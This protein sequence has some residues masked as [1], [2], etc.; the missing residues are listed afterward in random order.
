MLNERKRLMSFAFMR[1]YVRF[2]M[3]EMMVSI[4]LHLHFWQW[5]GIFMAR[6]H[7]FINMHVKHVQWKMIAPF[8]FLENQTDDASDRYH[9]MFIQILKHPVSVQY[10]LLLNI[11]LFTWTY[12]KKDPHFIQ[13]RLNRKDS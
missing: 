2:Y 10:L 4:Y 13:V 5:R 6:S 1:N 11:F 9:N 8:S 3:K 12:C 7:N